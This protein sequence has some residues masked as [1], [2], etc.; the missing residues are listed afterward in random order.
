MV[1]NRRRK[2]QALVEM[3]FMLPV[4]IMIVLVIIDLGRAY[5]VYASMNH[6]CLE[7]ARMG[8]RRLNFFVATNMFGANT[9][10]AFEHIHNAFVSFKSPLVATCTY[11]PPGNGFP[12]NPTPSVT[13][14]T[15]EGQGGPS[16]TIRVNAQC[17]IELYTPVIARLVQTGAWTGTYRLSASAFQDK[18]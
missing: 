4:F 2:G 12:A 15:V 6:Q 10:I 1:R 17:D 8:S 11:V 16:Q 18:E 9:H 14:F 3:A 13:Y 7:A 5:H